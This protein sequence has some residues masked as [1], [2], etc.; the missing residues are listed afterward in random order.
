MT[1]SYRKH[2]QKVKRKSAFLESQE[3]VLPPGCNNWIEYGLP[4]MRTVPNAPVAAIQQARVSQRL[5]VGP[6]RTPYAPKE[7]LSQARANLSYRHRWLEEE[8]LTDRTAATHKERR[9]TML[10]TA[11]LARERGLVG[12]FSTL[13]APPQY[14]SVTTVGHGRHQRSIPNPRFDPSLDPAAAIEWKRGQWKNARAK[15]SALGL[16]AGVDSFFYMSMHMHQDG[17]PHWHMISF[18]P[19]HLTV[20]VKA[21]LNGC[22]LVYFK[23]IKKEGGSVKY[24]ERLLAEQDSDEALAASLMPGRRWSSTQQ[25]REVWRWLRAVED[26][27]M[28]P[29]EL[30]EPWKAA[31]GLGE[32]DSREQA[33][34]FLESQASEYRLALS[35][36]R[37]VLIRLDERGHVII[38]HNYTSLLKE[39][40]LGVDSQV[41]A[42]ARANASSAS[43]VIPRPPGGWYK[44]QAAPAGPGL[45]RV[46]MPPPRR[47]R[48]PYIVP[49]PQ[50]IAPAP[51]LV[52]R[53]HTRTGGVAV[54]V[55]PIRRA[56]P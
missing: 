33:K 23:P 24:I 30:V 45:P 44:K 15:L 36:K 41:R 1:T 34:A 48:G 55:V 4:R 46:A 40:Q 42:G 19:P 32:G 56:A 18:F 2:P 5:G 54:A 51:C 37:P 52:P 29:Q 38:A 21:I 17:T 9:L 49:M 39:L 6:G 3:S 50:K 27:R 31:R 7:L 43:I 16:T 10:A 53:P 14:H 47:P 13:E 22:G 35:G 20:Q 8:E 11:A 26:S 12:H 25:A 28:L